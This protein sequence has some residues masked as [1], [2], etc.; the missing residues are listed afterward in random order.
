MHFD[1]VQYHIYVR[2]P[3]IAMILPANAVCVFFVCVRVVEACVRYSV[4]H[5]HVR[6]CIAT[7]T[8]TY[9]QLYAV[10]Q[11]RQSLVRAIPE[12]N[13]IRIRVK[14][15]RSWLIKPIGLCSSAVQ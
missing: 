13:H 4:W 10:M 5:V 3:S 15:S 8:H 12:C 9:G 1:W 14:W 2:R 7:C 6:M 11:Q